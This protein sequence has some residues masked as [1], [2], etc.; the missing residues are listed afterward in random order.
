MSRNRDL[1]EFAELVSHNLR[2]PLATIMGLSNLLAENL[3]DPERD[4]I[5]AGIG[6]SASQLDTVVRQMNTILNEKK[7]QP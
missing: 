7:Q 6:S 2:G 4:V 3:P 1:N 5:V